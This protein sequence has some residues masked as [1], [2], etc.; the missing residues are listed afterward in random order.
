MALAP[1]VILRKALAGE[2]IRVSDPG[3]VGDFIYA[4]DLADALCRLLRGEAEPRHEVY[5]VA[6]GKAVSVGQLVELVAE[7]VPGASYEVVP[8]EQAD[9][10]LSSAQVGGR[11]GAYDICRLQDEFGWQPRPLRQ[12]L[13]DYCD[14]LR[15]Q[16]VESGEED[17]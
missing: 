2:T 10:R 7:F 15:G 4:P 6:Y 13:A 5:N 11:W 16:A 17:L 14:W 1:L 9:V 12:A 8:D 3:G